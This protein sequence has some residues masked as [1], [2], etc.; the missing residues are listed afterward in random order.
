[1]P[2]NPEKSQ[3]TKVSLT[4]DHQVVSLKAK[5][6]PLTP[7]EIKTLNSIYNESILRLKRTV[8]LLNQLEHYLNSRE[9]KETPTNVKQ[10]LI[11]DNVDPELLHAL[12][13]VKRHF[14]LE[15]SNPVHTI[16]ETVHFINRIKNNL[17]KTL[18][19][20]EGQLDITLEISYKGH[21]D[22]PD[23]SF[24]Q[25]N[26]KDKT[27]VLVA[28]NSAAPLTWSLFYYQ[29]KILQKKIDASEV[30]PGI[31]TL[32]SVTE[33]NGS[34]GNLMKFLMAYH[35]LHMPSKTN[36]VYISNM[37]L[38]RQMD[39][40]SPVIGYVH[41]DESLT[42]FKGA[43]HLDY[44]LLKSNPDLAMKTL[45]HEAA[46]RYAWVNDRG[47][48]HSTKALKKEP[49]KTRPFP[50]Q[51]EQNPL[52]A[53]DNADSYSYFVSDVS[54]GDGLLGSRANLPQ[55]C[56][57]PQY[58]NAHKPLPEGAVSESNLLKYGMFGAG[59]AAALTVIGG[60]CYMAKSQNNPGAA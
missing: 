49:S 43:I 37:S 41:R 39:T 53:L 10:L 13:M 56:T 9:D 5:T 33:A 36:A 60:V 45:I 3:K 30:F 23:E 31:A 25:Q 32:Q 4:S 28:D 19:G 16:N 57:Q 38:K 35:A 8:D 6:Q 55:W 15:I 59:V 18:K 40:S 14:Y 26:A 20:L 1:M 58:A 52:F 21:G 46:H 2:K 54:G 12:K 29:D 22:E 24:I 47:Y 7:H 17:H 42:M 44:R 27:Y 34:K 50:A 48:Y 51:T 11:D